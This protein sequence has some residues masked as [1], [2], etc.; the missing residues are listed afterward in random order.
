MLV[1]L[2]A[3]HFEHFFLSVE[4]SSLEKSSSSQGGSLKLTCLNG[5]EYILKKNM[6]AIPGLYRG[7]YTD[8]ELYVEACPQF[9][10]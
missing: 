6:I 1:V 3:K 9:A 5:L 7:D 4:F 8:A 2:P 10:T